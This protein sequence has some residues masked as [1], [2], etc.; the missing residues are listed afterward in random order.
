M[1]SPCPSFPAATCRRHPRHV[2]GNACIK[3]KANIRPNQLH[4]GRGAPQPH[5]LLHRA[6]AIHH[7]GMVGALQLAQH[8]NRERAAEAVV[9][10]F[11]QQEAGIMQLGPWRGGHH[12]GTGLNA[13]GFCFRP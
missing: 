5:F 7:I 9:P 13:P 10:G 2:A 1:T 3:G 6:H 4:T 11:R 8:L 12:H